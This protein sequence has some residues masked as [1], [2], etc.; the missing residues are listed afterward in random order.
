[1]KPSRAQ[2]RVENPGLICGAGAADVSGG[3]GGRL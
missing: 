2:F 1:L 3:T